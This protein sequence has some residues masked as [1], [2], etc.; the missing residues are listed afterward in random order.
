MTKEDL[1]HKGTIST[2][3]RKKALLKTF[4][5]LGFIISSNL[6]WIILMLY[7]IDITDVNFSISVEIYIWIIIFGGIIPLGS[8]L[9]L[10]SAFYSAYVRKFSYNI[11]GDKIIINHGVLTRTRATLPYS[12]IQNIT[13]VNGIF[14]RMFK[15]FTVKIETAGSSG[16]AGGQGGKIRPEGYIPGLKDPYEIENKINEMLTKYSQ[17]PSGLEDKIFKPEELAFDN[18]ISYILSKMREGEKLKTSIKELMEK[19]GLSKA[20]LAEQVGVPIETINYLIEGRYNPSLS[21]AY[22]IA[23]VLN[24]KIEDLFKLA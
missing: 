24:C 22:K 20:K 21:L 19:N 23:K 17:I 6:L 15:T 10:S 1:S 13:I 9:V 14:D 2:D 8:L 11:T 18:F 12:R 5:I 3:Y 4:I 7:G 16:A